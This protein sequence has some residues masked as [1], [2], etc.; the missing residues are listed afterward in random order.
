MS[1]NEQR[2]TNGLPRLTK[3]QGGNAMYSQTDLLFANEFVQ[4]DFT[5]ID[6]DKSDNFRKYREKKNEEVSKKKKIAAVKSINEPVLLNLPSREERYANNI[7]S[8]QPS[9][10]G[11]G[12][13]K[14]GKSKWIE[15]KRKI[16][17]DSKDRNKILYPDAADFVISWGRSLQNVKTMKLVSLEFPNVV[18]AVS[19]YNNALHHINIEDAEL[20]PAFPTYSTYV[21]TGSYNY[22]SLQTEFTARL[23][24]NKRRGGT[25]DAN[26]LPPLRHLFI[27]EINQETDYVGFTSIV[28]QAAGNNPI[29]TTGGQSTVFFKQENHGYEDQERIHIIGV[30]GIIGGLQAADLNGAYIITKLNND[31]FS[32]EVN[33]VAQSTQTGGG[34]LTKTGR[35]APFQFMFGINPNPIADIIGFPV[36]NSSVTIPEMHPLTSNIKMITDVIPGRVFSEIVCPNHGMLPGD[37]IF[38]N[39]FHVSPS[40]YENDRYKGI[41]QVYAVPSP[42]VFT[43]R[44]FIEH[45]SDVTNAFV[46]TQTFSMYYPG[47]GFNR[48]TDIQQI[49]PNLVQITTLFDHGFDEKSTVRLSKTNCS[50][51]V[52]GFYKVTPIDSDS[53]AISSA[54]P[55]NALT[56]IRPGFRGILTSDHVFY[57]Y[58]VKPV[59]GFT[60]SDLNNVPFTIREIIDADNFTFS[61]NYGFSKYAETGGGPDVRI[62]SKLHGWRGTQSNTM[63]GELYKPIKLSGDNY[64]FM[65][66]PGL[67]SDSISNS[68]PVK[69]IFAKVFISAVPGVTI[70]NEFDASPIDFPRPIPLLNELRFVITSPD[71]HA[72]SFGGLDYSFGLEVTEMV[73]VDENN[74]QNSTRLAPPS[75]GIG[76]IGGPSAGKALA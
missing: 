28:P 62:N 69:D 18:P 64:A 25:L 50:P 51:N 34:T 59:G 32:F 57:L 15:M 16:F 68:G 71:N 56:L 39:N 58:N 48:I 17:I 3:T 63:N 11:P 2:N 24:A 45:V 4:Q 49:G 46:G 29:I 35:E 23:K 72:I 54:D 7:P 53:F 6:K 36:E 26:G 8:L 30:M 41:F 52:D 10:Q 66:I 5:E 74:E 37:R 47:H 76:S 38:L 61:G 67:N 73:Q 65:C 13:A 42:D 27:V 40:V 55:T 19:V 9:V 60:A 31:R 75:M 20:E 44:Y 21:N 22:S 33:A 43:I 70:F 14:G 12:E 1:N